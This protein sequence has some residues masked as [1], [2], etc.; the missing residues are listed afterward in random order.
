MSSIGKTKSPSPPSPTKAQNIG[1]G[2]IA[3]KPERLRALRSER[4]KELAASMRE[5]GLLQPIILRTGRGSTY[6]LVAGFHR[7]EA[8]RLL[9]WPS[10]RAEV[11]ERMDAD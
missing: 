8:A 3:V 2:G 1:L 4:V 7:L 9:K 11:F 6:W 10:I 5:C